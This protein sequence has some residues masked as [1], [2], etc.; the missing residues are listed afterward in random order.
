LKGQGKKQ[1]ARIAN[2]KEKNQGGIIILMRFFAVDKGG[3]NISIG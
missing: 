3:H 2:I 1:N